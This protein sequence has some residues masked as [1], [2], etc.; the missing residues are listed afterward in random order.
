MDRLRV[1]FVPGNGGFD[2][3]TDIWYPF[4]KEGLEALGMH[5]VDAGQYPDPYTG[6]MSAWLPYILEDLGVDENTIVIGH[7]TG[8]VAAMRLAETTQLFGTVLVWRAL[9]MPFYVSLVH[10]SVL[11]SLSSR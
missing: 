4:L 9:N 2:T 8:A 3:S 5:V 11:N 1:V 10:S 6:R 7:S